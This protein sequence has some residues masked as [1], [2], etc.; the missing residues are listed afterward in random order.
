MFID[1][2][3]LLIRHLFIT[4]LLIGYLLIGCV[5]I[6]YLLIGLR[7]VRELVKGYNG[8]IG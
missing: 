1:C 7:D 3:Y 6:V 4:Y 2:G 8:D 5:L